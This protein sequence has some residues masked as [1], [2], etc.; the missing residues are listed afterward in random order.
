MTMGLIT[1]DTLE[2]SSIHPPIMMVLEIE[3]S[4]FDT[5]D[6]YWQY[7]LLSRIGN[8]VHDNFVGPL[9]HMKL[10]YG[11]DMEVS[12]TCRFQVKTR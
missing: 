5:F 6:R 2:M 9:E 3:H 7:I 8:V 4:A 11:V 12:W 1:A 10:G